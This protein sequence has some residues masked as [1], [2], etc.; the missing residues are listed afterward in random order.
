MSRRLI[1]RPLS[2]FQDFLRLEAASGIILMAA[3]ALALLCANSPAADLYARLIASE[4]PLPGHASL[5][6]MVNDG[7]MTLFFLLVGLEIKRELV[8]GE[9]ASARRM[10]LP[11]LAALG[12]MIAPAGIYLALNLQGGPALRGWAISSATDIAFALGVLSLIGARVPASLKAFLTALAILDDLG[13]IVIIA[14]FYTDA[15]SMPALA[16]AL[17]GIAVLIA[18]NRIG[19]RRL[20]PYLLIGI[21]VWGCVLASGVHPTLAGVAVALTIPLRRSD[22]DDAPLQRLEHALHPW[23]AYGIIPLFGFVNAG[24]AFGGLTVD[25]LLSRVTLGIAAGLFVG[26]QLGVALSCRLA[27]GA[28]LA[29]LPAGAT[30]PQFYAVALLCGIGFTMSLFI[31]ALAFPS[32]ALAAETK[33]GV[34]LGSFASA[35][36]GYAA[37]RSAIR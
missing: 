18:L 13:A 27:C 4:L 16:L 36:C 20:A 37:M 7:L 14:L 35:L 29:A 28:R 9:L 3:A 22:T 24:L 1:T 33:L 31:G 30:W 12:G 23:V 10:A 25:H 34:L 5:L 15:L 6:H 17:G 26:K 2:A 21:G 8:V 11:A 32:P 19:Q